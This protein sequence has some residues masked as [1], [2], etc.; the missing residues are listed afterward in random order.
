MYRP[1]QS[2]PA[3]PMVSSWTLGWGLVSEGTAGS[4]PASATWESANRG[5]WN[6]VLVPVACVAR[7]MWW[8][9][10]STV[11]ASYNVEAGIYTSVD[12]LPSAKLVTTGSVAQG[13]A[14]T[15]Q[16]ADITDT[17]LSPG[18]YWLYMSCSSASATFFRSSASTANW[19][20]L[21][22]FTQD[23]VGPGSAPTTATPVASSSTSIVLFGFATTASP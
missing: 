13:T 10:G 7:R 6:P 22:R 21:I 23:S 8:A 4:P 11:S 9:N 5:V 18:M 19:A 16:F 1:P 17:V 12:Y 2:Q 14:S 20:K 3:P 15:I